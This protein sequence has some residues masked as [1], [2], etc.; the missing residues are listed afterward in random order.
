MKEYPT[1]LLVL[2]SIDRIKNAFPKGF[3]EI[4]ILYYFYLNIFFIINF[5]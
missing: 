2:K 3:F 4:Y 1:N 5:N